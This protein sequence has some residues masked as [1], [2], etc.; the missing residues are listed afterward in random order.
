VNWSQAI[1][2]GT[3]PNIFYPVSKG[4]RHVQ[5]TDDLEIE[6]AK[7]ICSSC[8]IQVECLEYALAN[9]MDDGVWGGKSEEQRKRILRQR[10][11]RSAA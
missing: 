2:R 11:R 8:P 10:R 3:D 9:R 1:C 7:R 4:G 6:V 5:S